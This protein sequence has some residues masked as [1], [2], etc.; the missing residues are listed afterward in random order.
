MA[1]TIDFFSGY[2]QIVL[3]VRSRDLTG[4]QTPIGTFT[5]DYASA[6]CY[7]LSCPIRTDCNQDS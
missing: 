4:F 7:E 5:D 3:D 1:S 2:D 6:G